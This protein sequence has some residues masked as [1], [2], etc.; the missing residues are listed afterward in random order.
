M[1]K[2]AINVGAVSEGEAKTGNA[3]KLETEAGTQTG[4]GMLLHINGETVRPSRSRSPFNTV[5]INEGKALIIDI[6]F[7]STWVAFHNLYGQIWL[8]C[9]REFMS[10]ARDFWWTMADHRDEYGSLHWKLTLS[11]RKG[12]SRDFF[13]FNM[14]ALFLLAKRCVG[15]EEFI[16]MAK[17]IYKHFGMIP[18]RPSK[19]MKASLQNI[20][21]FSSVIDRISPSE[22]G[23][24]KVALA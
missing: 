1:K 17:T 24:S 12:I 2:K 10:V 20:T 22:V 9:E 8:V 6:P 3:F 23:N 7:I 16:Q 4:G 21:A 19:N 18:K 13:F 15:T 14:D 11:S 5:D